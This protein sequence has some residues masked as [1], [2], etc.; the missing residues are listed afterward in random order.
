MMFTIAMICQ[1]CNYRYLLNNV[2][3]P[4]FQS[5]YR[6][7]SY[8]SD[9][10]PPAGRAEVK[11]APCQSCLWRKPEPVLAAEPGWEAQGLGCME[12]F[13]P[14]AAAAW[15]W[16]C[17]GLWGSQRSRAGL[18]GGSRH[19]KGPWSPPG[20]PLQRGHLPRALHCSTSERAPRSFP[21]AHEVA[22]T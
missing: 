12:K 5:W 21:S 13:G 1:R 20:L 4:L 17:T 3:L 15:M 7:L 2:C 8:P 10:A 9:T 18:E 11:L 16:G 19:P 22:S 6:C 14:N